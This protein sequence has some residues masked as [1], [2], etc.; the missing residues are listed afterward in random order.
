MARTILLIPTYNEEHTILDV[1]DRAYALVNVLIVVDDGSRD[2]TSR[3][4]AEWCITRANMIVLT[5]TKN[6]GM[7][8]ALR[9]GFAFLLKGLQ[10]GDFDPDDVVATIDADGQLLPE[11]IP[12]ALAY[13]QAHHVDVLLGRRDLS[14]Y[15]AFKQVGN[16]LLSA[17]AS[18]L[19]GTLYHD[20]EC[21]FR[22]MRLEVLRDIFSFFKGRQY[23]CAQEL[24]IIIP[25]RHWRVDNSFP[26]T[27]A[28]YRPGARIEDGLTNAIMGLLSLLR[29]W[30]LPGAALDLQVDRVL[31]GTR[32]P[33]SDGISTPP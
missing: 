29:V 20:A 23:G 1:L 30:L 2:R 21:G 6:Q 16:R 17:W 28:Y 26:T 27:V 5:H 3:L 15:P 11:E 9:T 13:M 14:G 7:S 33:P 10:A 12:M 24:A 4:V 19:A 32:L 18:L 31:K 22:L 25:R 8:G